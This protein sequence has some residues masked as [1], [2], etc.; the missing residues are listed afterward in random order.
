MFIDSFSSN[1]SLPVL[2]PCIPFPTCESLPVHQLL[3]Q[4]WEMQ[5][6]T[7]LAQPCV[8]QGMRTYAHPQ[9]AVAAF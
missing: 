4:S 7:V 9:A 6:Y 1:Q 3:T 2:W 8:A 5:G